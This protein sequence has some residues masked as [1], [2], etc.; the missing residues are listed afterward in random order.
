M[1]IL[2]IFIVL[3][4]QYANGNSAIQVDIACP[5]YI[6]I[7]ISNSALGYHG[8]S[9][10]EAIDDT[11]IRYA[12]RF[13]FTLTFL[14][15]EVRIRDGFDFTA[16]SLDLITSWYYRSSESDAS[17]KSNYK[18]PAPM[19][20]GLATVTLGPLA[21]TFVNAVG[22]FNW[23]SVFLVVDY[24]A[25]LGMFA[26]LGMEISKIVSDGNAKAGRNVM[27]LYERRVNT[28]LSTVFL[29]QMDIILGEF[30]NTSRVMIFLARADFVRQLLLTARS[31][32]MTDGEFVYLSYEIKLG[33]DLRS[34]FVDRSDVFEP[35]L[36]LHARDEERQ[37]LQSPQVTALAA[38]VRRRSLEEFNLNIP[39]SRQPLP[40]IATAYRSIEIFAQVLNESQYQHGVASLYD[41]YHLSRLFLNR[42]FPSDL[43]SLFVDSSGT[44]RIEFVLS[45][46]PADTEYVREAFMVQKKDDNFAFHVVHNISGSWP[47]GRWPPPNE[48]YCGY[49]NE[50]ARCF[51]DNVFPRIV[52]GAAIGTLAALLSLFFATRQVIRVQHIRSLM[53]WNL[54]PSLLVGKQQPIQRRAPSFLFRS[55]C[56]GSR[57]GINRSGSDFERMVQRNW[58]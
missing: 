21:M 24:G 40:G 25:S 45:H 17:S 36:L 57:V 4:S 8:P 47:G 56:V 48:P 49:R 27:T 39:A 52:A 30:R 34:Q 2:F 33:T 51:S 44:S 19:I 5:G 14:V 15:D 12:G 7:S 32:N 22:T 43:Y 50:K 16:E 58:Y 46:F 3:L 35:L 29:A 38:K 1:R 26:Y 10:E 20:I 31:L 42:S 37:R 28:T 41:G 55:L 9:F 18:L 13:N 54:E 53:W 23:T 11:N 6:N